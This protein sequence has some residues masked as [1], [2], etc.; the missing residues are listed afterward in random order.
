MEDVITALINCKQLGFKDVSSAAKDLTVEND[1][2]DND[3]EYITAESGAED[4]RR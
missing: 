4:S 1:D 3:V 2:V